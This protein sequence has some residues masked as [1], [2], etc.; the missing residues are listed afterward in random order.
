MEVA[1]HE[2]SASWEKL[3]SEATDIVRRHAIEL[4]MDLSAEECAK[5]AEEVAEEAWE[6]TGYRVQA[7]EAWEG[8]NLH[9]GLYPV[10]NLHG[11]GDDVHG[12]D[13]DDQAAE[14]EAEAETE[15]PPRLSLAQLAD[16]AVRARSPRSGAKS[17]RS[18]R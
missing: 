7:E 10:P 4:Q 16:A 2:I 8:A 6:G 11:G 5:L 9:G 18:M 17:S 12:G 15:A 3:L 14:A 13:G 1:A